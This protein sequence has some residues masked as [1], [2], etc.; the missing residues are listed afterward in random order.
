MSAEP[1]QEASLAPWEQHCRFPALRSF[2]VA[3][4]VLWKKALAL[5]YLYW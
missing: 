2:G 3:K 1:P 4:A 5:E